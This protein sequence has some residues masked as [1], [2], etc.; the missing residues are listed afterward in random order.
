MEVPDVS[1]CSSI[2]KST[3]SLIA[4][5]IIDK[6]PR[7]AGNGSGIP[8]ALELGLQISPLNA[9]LRSTHKGPTAVGHTRKASG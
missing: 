3:F 5:G 2:S 6:A 4:L 9:N 8:Q 7:A 1:L